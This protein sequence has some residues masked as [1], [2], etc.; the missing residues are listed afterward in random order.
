MRHI[1]RLFVEKQVIVP[2]LVPM[3]ALKMQEWKM[4][5]WKMQER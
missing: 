3:G 2:A 1:S 4:Q 5:E